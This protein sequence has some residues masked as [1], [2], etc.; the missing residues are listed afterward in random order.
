MSNYYEYL[1]EE[2]SKDLNDHWETESER[3]HELCFILSL[4]EQPV[5][6]TFFHLYAAD[7]NANKQSMYNAA[8]FF[9]GMDFLHIECDCENEDKPYC[10]INNLKHSLF[11]SIG[12][13]CYSTK[14]DI[15]DSLAARIAAVRQQLEY[16]F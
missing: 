3:A 6:E 14:N 4:S 16:N 11:Y 2:M 5:S 1:M 10:N 9:K 7:I 12:F 8:A 13:D 15:W